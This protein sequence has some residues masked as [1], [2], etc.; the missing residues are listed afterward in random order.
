[1]HAVTVAHIKEDIVLIDTKADPRK[2]ILWSTLLTPMQI[3]TNLRFQNGVW[4][5]FNYVVIISMWIFSISTSDHADT[6]IQSFWP[7]T[8]GNTYC[9]NDNKVFRVLN[10]VAPIILVIGL[11]SQI[12]I[13]VFE[14]NQPKK[15]RTKD[16]SL[17]I[18][19]TEYEDDDVLDAVDAAEVK[20]YRIEGWRHAEDDCPGCRSQ[21]S[22]H[23]HVYDESQASRAQSNFS[24]IIS[25]LL[26][27]WEN[28]G[29]KNT[30]Q[31]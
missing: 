29:D 25:P 1:M 5:V 20:N 21:G 26:N 10:Y 4:F 6:E 28:F 27:I 23:R 3:R 19:L 30:A 31:T 24:L 11:L 8:P 2:N 7:F 16:K 9:L 17:K 18:Q 15:T 12:I 22:W 13:W 14:T